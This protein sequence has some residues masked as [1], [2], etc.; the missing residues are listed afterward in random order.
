M[1]SFAFALISVYA[2]AIKLTDTTQG[3]PPMPT[4]PMPPTTQGPP[5]GTMPPTDAPACPPG[6]DCMPPPP[7]TTDMPA[8]PPGTD[9]MP[10]PPTTDMPPYE[11]MP[12]SFEQ[13][14]ESLYYCIDSHG[15]QD[16]KV[17]LMELAGALYLG[18]QAGALPMEAI[19]SFGE[20][21]DVTGLMADHMED[22]EIE[23]C[24]AGDGVIMAKELGECVE[25]KV[26]ELVQAEDWEGIE[27]LMKRLHAVEISKD[28][29]AAG[30][31]ATLEG[32]EGLDEADW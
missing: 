15:E 13:E 9:C 14:A 20:N 7:P 29:A 5:P 10:P 25:G 22:G 1:K 16:G 24:A 11:P 27:T 21:V 32:I 6:T 23:A 30:L 12:L 26:N 4:A 3:P 18:V 8:C 31:K 17:S 19:D 28:D 2:C